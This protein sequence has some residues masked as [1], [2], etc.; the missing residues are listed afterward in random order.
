MITQFI[1]LI[2]KGAA[3]CLLPLFSYNNLFELTNNKPYTP[4]PFIYIKGM[5]EM[6]KPFL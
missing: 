4:K 6:S 1:L 2:L 3:E 5:Q